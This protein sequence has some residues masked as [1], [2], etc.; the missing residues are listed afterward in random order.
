MIKLES[1]APMSWLV[2]NALAIIC[3]ATPLLALEFLRERVEWIDRHHDL[4]SI[5][6]WLGTLV[7]LY[8]FFGMLG[9]VANPRLQE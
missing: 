2:V 5:V 3:L 6:L 9:F 8:A 7:G 1:G 4:L